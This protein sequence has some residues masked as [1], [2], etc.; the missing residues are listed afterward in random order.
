[1]Y[2]GWTYTHPPTIFVAYVQLNMHVSSPRAVVGAVLK[3]IP[4]WR[5][6]STT[7]LPSLARV[8]EDV[9]NPGESWCARV[10]G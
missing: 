2:M 8:E 3:L 9:A 7:E 5:I 6:H 1:M 10:A 4:L